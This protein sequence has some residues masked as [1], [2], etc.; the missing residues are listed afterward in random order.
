MI[1]AHQPGSEPIT[2]PEQIP[3]PAVRPRVPKPAPIPEP[4]KP[5]QVPQRSALGSALRPVGC[6]PSGLAGSADVYNLAPPSTKHLQN[7][8][9]AIGTS[10]PSCD[11]L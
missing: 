9:E 7:E 4:R 8:D 11:C 2:I 6:Q 10:R 3:N 5:V 1:I